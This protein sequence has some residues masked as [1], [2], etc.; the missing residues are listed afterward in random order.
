ME[1]EGGEDN[2]EEIEKYYHRA[3]QVIGE[4]ERRALVIKNPETGGYHLF[5][6]QLDEWIIDEIFADME[7]LRG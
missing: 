7:D 2:L 3:E 4:L 6:A 1:R 5:S